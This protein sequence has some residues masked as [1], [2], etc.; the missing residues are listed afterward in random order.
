MPP[1]ASLDLSAGFQEIVRAVEDL[2][3]PLESGG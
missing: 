2:L 1:V 3:G